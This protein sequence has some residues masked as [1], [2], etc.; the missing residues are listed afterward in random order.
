MVGTAE[1]DTDRDG[2]SLGLADGIVEGA[3][4]LESLPPQAQH[5]S[6]FAFPLYGAAK[7]FAQASTL[8]VA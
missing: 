8:L 3:T 4:S 7:V 2:S 1:G 6:Q 5:A